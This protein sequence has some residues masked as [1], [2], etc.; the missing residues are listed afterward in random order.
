[1]SV[2]TGVVVLALGLSLGLSGCGRD[3]DVVAPAPDTRTDRSAPVT[4]PEGVAAVATAE[5]GAI[6]NRWEAQTELSRTVTGNLTASLEAG[7]GGP[8]VLAFANGITMRL[9]RVADQLG[10]DRTGSANVTFSS[11]L[12]A[13]PNAQVFIYR[14]ADERLADSASRGGLCQGGRT[15]HVALSE[16]V[17]RQGDW[18]FTLAA[19]RGSVQ[20]GPGA[21]ADPQFCA[22]YGYGVS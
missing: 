1:M 15:A 2:R 13:D 11:T 18:V 17:N 10:A 19:Y 21:S 8:L 5:P 6:R 12:G 7:R 22:A 4:L 16:F 20:P 14:V 3:G 9:E